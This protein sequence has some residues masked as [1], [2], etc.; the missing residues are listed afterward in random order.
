MD[1]VNFNQ[2]DLNKNLIGEKGP[3]LSENLEVT[4]NFYNDKAL[5]VSLPNQITCR[6]K[7]TDASIKGQTVSSSYKPAILENGISIQVPPFIENED[8]VIIDTRTMEYVKKK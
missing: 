6:I 1:P 7:S 2:V 3:M 8:E 4:I 5:S